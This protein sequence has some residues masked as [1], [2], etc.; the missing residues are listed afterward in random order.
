MRNSNDS[1]LMLF[2]FRKSLVLLVCVGNV[3]GWEAGL[4]VMSKRNP[5]T[6]WAFITKAA[7]NLPGLLGIALSGFLAFIWH[8]TAPTATLPLWITILVGY[9][10]LLVI[11]IMF[12]ALHSAAI[13]VQSAVEVLCVKTPHPPYLEA[14][15]I[16]VVRSYGALSM[17]STVS[18]YRL[19][20]KFERLVGIGTVVRL[21]TDGNYQI[22]F[23]KAVSDLE[24]DTYIRALQ[25]NEAN[26]VEELRVLVNVSLSETQRH[27]PESKDAS[28]KSTAEIKAESEKGE[29][30]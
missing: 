18:F 1:A 12:I 15:C 19:F 22:T 11:I 23:D 8:A 16:L 26:A 2:L 30:R 5:T 4:T 24:I 3:C 13:A 7:L 20:Q 17:N 29:E 6:A 9:L 25:S 27:L 28:A 10:S 14:K 21:Q